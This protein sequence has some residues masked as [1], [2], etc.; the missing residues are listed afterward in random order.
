MCVIGPYVKE[1]AF[2]KIIRIADVRPST[3]EVF[4]QLT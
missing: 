1:E 2:H 3:V 4:L